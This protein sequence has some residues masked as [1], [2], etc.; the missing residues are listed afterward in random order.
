VVEGIR[1]FLAP[2]ELQ[3]LAR[4]TLQSRYVVEGNLAGRHRSPNRGASTEFADHRA[5]IAGDDPKRID[6]KVLGRTERYYVR[7][8]EDET[9]LRVYFVVD[10]SASMGYGSGAVTKYD[11]ACRLAA[12]LGYVVVKARDSV[13]LY[14]YSNRID[15]MAGA[16]NSFNHLNNLLKTLQKHKPALTTETAITLHQIAEDVHR[17]GLI[18]LL[19]DLLDQPAEVVKALAHFRKQHHDVILLQVMDPME[20]DFAFKQAAEFEDLETGEKLVTDPRA[21]AEEYQRA[22]EAFLEEY[23]GPCAEMNIDYRLVNTREPP[24]EF[25][26]AYLEERRRLSK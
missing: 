8:Y 18:V 12:A 21:L 3:Q 11:Y 10:R 23:R 5:Y 16:R 6:W 9:N 24:E 22:L 14:L 2:R 13:G 26:R 4:L 15:A 20:L 1:H 25:V 17:R 19:S 7:R